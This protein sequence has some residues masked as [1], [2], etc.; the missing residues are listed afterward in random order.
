MHSSDL[1][2]EKTKHNKSANSSLETKKL[3]QN[4]RF[5]SI[6]LAMLKYR[7]TPDV[8]PIAPAKQLKVMKKK[9]LIYY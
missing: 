4:Y 2:T 3:N 7:I 1:S 6:G 9:K 5:L 8:I